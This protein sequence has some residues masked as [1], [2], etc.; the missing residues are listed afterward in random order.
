MNYGK[1]SC[2]IPRYDW[3]RNEPNDWHSQNCL[4][5]LKDQVCFA[6][7]LLEGNAANLSPLATDLTTGT[8]GIAIPPPD[9]SA[10]GP[11]M[12]YERE[13][14]YEINRYTA[15][16]AFLSALHTARLLQHTTLYPQLNTHTQIICA[17]GVD[18]RLG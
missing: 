17:S 11:H 12:K 3:M 15:N 10:R 16:L 6:Q 5:F 2:L 9:T 13:L 14:Y 1:M 8:T 18:A 4:T 7:F